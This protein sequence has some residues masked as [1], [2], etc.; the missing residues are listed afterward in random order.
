MR[1]DRHDIERTIFGGIIATLIVTALMFAATKLDLPNIDMASALGTA[2]VAKGAA[3]PAYPLTGA[4]WLG[5]ALFFVVG[6][7]LSPLV[8]AYAFGGLLGSPWLRG[9]EWAVFLWIIGGV[10]VMTAMGLGFNDAHGNHPISSVLA[11]LAAHLIYGVV[12]GQVAGTAFRQ[13]SSVHK[14]A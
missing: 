9:V 4:W 11:S 3:F 2:F 13:P 6:A 14:A 8:F 10:G 7:V 1:P 12:L 5:L